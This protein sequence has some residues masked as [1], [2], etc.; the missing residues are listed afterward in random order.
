MSATYLKEKVR[1][2]WVVPRNGLITYILSRGVDIP[3]KSSLSFEATQKTLYNTAAP[4]SSPTYLPPKKSLYSS[5]FGTD[6]PYIIFFSPCTSQTSLLDHQ[7]DTCPSELPLSISRHPRGYHQFPNRQWIES[8][9]AVFSTSSHSTRLGTS[10]SFSRP[11]PLSAKD[12]SSFFLS[13]FTM[14]H[15]YY[16]VKA[17]ENCLNKSFLRQKKTHSFSWTNGG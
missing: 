5:V 11:T 14:I 3:S 12:H 7:L 2:G 6:R 15:R 17:T 13:P 4:C 8:C 10:F 9:L 1:G 16:R